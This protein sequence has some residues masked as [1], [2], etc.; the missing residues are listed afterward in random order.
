MPLNDS[1]LDKADPL[2]PPPSRHPAEIFLAAAS[3]MSGL[4]SLLGPARPGSVRAIAPAWV[5][6]GWATVLI[7]GGTICLIAALIQRRARRLLVERV[8]IVFLGFGAAA[9]SLA[10]FSVQGWRGLYPA[11]VTLGF[12][13]ACIWRWA[14][15]ERVLRG[16][17]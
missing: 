11:L 17:Q 8:G 1:V 12:S 2:P 4:G 3:V 6:V 13:A 9:Y 10:V 5:G 16:K 14:Q 15:I 7:V